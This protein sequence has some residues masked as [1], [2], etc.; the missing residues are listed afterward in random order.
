MRGPEREGDGGD[1]GQSG[2]HEAFN[3][4]LPNQPSAS[5]P[6]R[7]SERELGPPRRR[8][9]EHQIADVRAGQEQDEPGDGQQN[10]QRLRELPAK[11]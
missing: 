11:I 10:E 4:H 6:Q 1:T 9:G 5:G 2:E 7:Q 8:P 3:E